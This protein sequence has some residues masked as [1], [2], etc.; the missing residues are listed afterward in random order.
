[1]TTKPT[2]EQLDAAR[3]L[4]EPEPRQDVLWRWILAAAFLL[5]AVPLLFDLVKT[6]GV[7]GFR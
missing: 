4:I 6:W 3:R 5:L 2:P 7:E 1:M